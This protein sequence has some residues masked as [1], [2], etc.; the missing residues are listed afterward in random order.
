MLTEMDSSTVVDADEA[1]GRG[2]GR[3]MLEHDEARARAR[4]QRR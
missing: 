1:R 3:R 2:V 4:E